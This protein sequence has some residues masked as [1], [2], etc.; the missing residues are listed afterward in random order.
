MSACFLSR[1]WVQLPFIPNRSDLFFRISLTFFLFAWILFVNFFSI[2]ECFQVFC[3]AGVFFSLFF[4]SSSSSHFF[5]M[6]NQ[7]WLQACH[8]FELFLSLSLSLSLSLAHSH[9]LC[10][11]RT[12]TLSLFLTVHKFFKGWTPIHLFT[13]SVRKKSFALAKDLTE[14]SDTQLVER[15]IKMDQIKQRLVLWEP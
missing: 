9:S 15:S 13:L 14:N 7:L 11:A 4:S 12:H 8:Y 3:I 10:L 1:P 6:M 2:I 5:P